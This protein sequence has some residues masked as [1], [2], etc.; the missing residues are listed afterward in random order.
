MIRSK[1]SLRLAT[2]T[3][4]SLLMAGCG[5]DDAPAPTATESSA[6]GSY[7]N[8]GSFKCSVGRP[9]RALQ[10]TESAVVEPGTTA[11]ITVNG[12]PAMPASVTPASVAAYCSVDG[13]SCIGTSCE[14]HPPVNFIDEKG[15]GPSWEIIH[16]NDGS[17]QMVFTA[18]AHNTDSI[19]HQ[20]TLMIDMPS[21]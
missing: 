20:V 21:N 4:L 19:P 15:K 5:Q 2:I 13:Q 9:W 10:I 17:S 16:A 18:S 6:M 14:G 3:S 8:T 1:P 12:P 7:E 11:K